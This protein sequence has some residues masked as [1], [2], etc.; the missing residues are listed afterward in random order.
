MPGT[1]GS[2]RLVSGEL[3]IS[4]RGGLWILKGYTLCY[5]VLGTGRSACATRCDRE[6]RQPYL[7]G[8]RSAVV[9]TA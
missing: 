5:I 3:R 7:D 9:A 2:D 6:A 4:V 8:A 1:P